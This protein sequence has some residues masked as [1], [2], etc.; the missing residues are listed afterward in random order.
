MLMRYYFS[1]LCI[2]FTLFLASAN[3]AEQQTEAPSKQQEQQALEQ[4]KE[5]MYKPLM[6]RYIL[7]ELK[8]VRQDQQK[9]REDVT[10]QVTHAQLDTADRALTYTTDTIN[11]VF[12]YYYCDGIYFG[13]CWLELAARC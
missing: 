6:E 2:C 10:K 12:F 1:L 9:L 7:D 13:T 5:P 4:L 8:A 3:A 11:N